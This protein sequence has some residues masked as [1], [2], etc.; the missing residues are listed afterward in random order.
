M[1]GVLIA[2]PF[3]VALAVAC[4]FALGRLMPRASDFPTPE[5]ARAARQAVWERHWAANREAEE[6][7]ARAEWSSAQMT[8]G[9]AFA[10]LNARYA[11]PLTPTSTTEERAMDERTRAALEASIAHW[12]TNA[13]ATHPGD[14]QTDCDACALCDLFRRPPRENCPVAARA[15]KTMCLGTPYG[16][17]RAKLMH[18]SSAGEAFRAAALREVAFLESLRDPPAA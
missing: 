10:Q 12:K 2:A 13:A 17:A 11:T 9:A 16:D 5:E 3:V 1:T 7:A 14:V 8:G 15:G 18:W 4:G 6:I